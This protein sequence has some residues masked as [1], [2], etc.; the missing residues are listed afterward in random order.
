MTNI[1]KPT[2]PRMKKERRGG[3]K[4]ALMYDSNEHQSAM[5]RSAATLFELSVWVVNKTKFWLLFAMFYKW[6]KTLFIHFHIM[7]LPERSEQLR[8]K[9]VKHAMRGKGASERN[10]HGEL[11]FV[12]FRI[13]LLSHP[14]SSW[15]SFLEWWYKAFQMLH[16]MAEMLWFLRSCSVEKPGDGETPP[17]G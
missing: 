9:K 1:R 5:K 10:W 13:H 11:A 16:Q 6:I 14:M 12:Y 3:A 7:H 15:C 17:R 8:D 4:R 2:S